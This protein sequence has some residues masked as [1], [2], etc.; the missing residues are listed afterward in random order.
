LRKSPWTYLLVPVVVAGG[1]AAGKFVAAFSDINAFGAAAL[2]AVFATAPV[3]VKVFA[4]AAGFSVAE[5]GAG[6]G[7]DGADCSRAA[8]RS[9]PVF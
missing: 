3:A 9:K 6:A 7:E 8:S 2:V 5:A 4:G 1:V